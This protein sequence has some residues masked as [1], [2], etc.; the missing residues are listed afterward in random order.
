MTSCRRFSLAL[1]VLP[2][3]LL[4]GCG[5]SDP[6]SIVSISLPRGPIAL[7]AGSTTQLAVTG[8]QG[9]GTQVPVTSGA[10]FTSSVPAVAVVDASGL[11]TGVS[12]GTAVITAIVSGHTA[13]VVVDVTVT[14]VSIAV[15]P[16]PV[17]VA[18]AGTQQLTVTGTY[19][20][21]T[22]AN[23]TAGSTFASSATGVATV[24]AG[25]LV[26]GVA[27]G[28]ATITATHTASGKTA[29]TTVTVSTPAPV[30]QSIAVTPSPVTVAIAGTQQL[31]VTGTY[32]DSTTANLTAGSTFASSATGSATV[33]AGGLVTG[34]AAGTA[35]ITATHTASGRTATTTVTVG[36]PA[37]VLQSIAVTPSPVTVAVAG[38]QQLTVT[39][40]YSDSS[41][42]NLTA[43]STFASSATGVATVSAG[44][45]VTGVAAGTATITATH[46]ASA[47]TSTAAVAVSGAPPTGGLVFLGDYD[48][49]VTFAGFGGAV[50][51][52]TIDAS[53][54]L[55]GRSSL[56]FVVTAAAG[57]YSGGAFVASVP[58]NLSAFNALTFWAMASTS[59]TLNYTGIGD[60]GADEGYRADSLGVPLTGTWTKYVIP[61]PAP[62]KLTASTGLFYLSEANKGY[63]IWLNDIQYENLGGTEVG[64][65]TG[66]TVTW[67]AAQSVAAGGTYQIDSQANTVSFAVPVLPNAGKL[68]SVGFRYFDLASSAPSVATV[69]ALGLV[70]G[71]AAGTASVTATLRSVAVPGSLAVTVPGGGP[72]PTAPTTTAAAPTALAANVIPLWNSSATYSPN[73][74]VD[75]WAASWGFPST[76]T[77]YVIGT[78]TVL[79]YVGVNYVGVEFLTHPIDASTYTHFH[80]DVWTPNATQF[81]VKLVNDVNG[82]TQAES[83]VSF[84]LTTTP[85]ITT[86]TWI[87]LDIP[88]TQFTGMGFNKLGQVLWIDNVGGP[89]GATFFIDNVYFWK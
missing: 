17:A 75:T 13:N 36:T 68:T 18:V 67:P 59:N 58:R 89:E 7:E 79:R 39:G 19:S 77:D 32:S 81:G 2:V 66:A 86:G 30:L 16:S 10:T 3:L 6:A 69:S 72:P 43:G 76:V 9:N 27:A 45:L 84:N 25:G 12:G 8:M 50:N 23:L 38:T 28:T 57:A 64:A 29:T 4:A 53:Q 31:T 34:V 11:V 41:T 14:L 74:P 71:Q 85:A 60:P 49:G 48:A 51:D 20:D 5:S 65:P 63:T 61:I 15:T 80:V 42:A 21:S 26:T 70:T 78:A 22:T 46:T 40:T 33:S 82:G 88:L 52:V 54:P 73:V 35:T 37:P 47:L 62:A 44:G 1:A 83:T 55:H 87:S 56:K 24:S